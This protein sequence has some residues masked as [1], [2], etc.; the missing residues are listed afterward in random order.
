[1]L[2]LRL[3]REILKSYREWNGVYQKLEE[4]RAWEYVGLAL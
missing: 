3:T 1:M 4:S 2:S